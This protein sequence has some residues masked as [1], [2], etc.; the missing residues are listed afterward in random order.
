M[1]TGPG[2]K[3]MDHVLMG[4]VDGASPEA[5]LAWVE[6]LTDSTER[7]IRYES[8][9][10]YLQDTHPDKAWTSLITWPDRVAAQ[11]LAAASLNLWAA[12]DPAAAA[13]A[14]LAG[15]DAWRNR[16]FAFNLAQ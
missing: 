5:P 8:L 12:L 6:S 2:M 14:W 4:W 11:G 10:G 9:I 3:L 15:P 7:K 1:E 13:S 16:H